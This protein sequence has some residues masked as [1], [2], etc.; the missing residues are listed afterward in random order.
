[1]DELLVFIIWTLDYFDSQEIYNIQ[2]ALSIPDDC[3]RQIRR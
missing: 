1:M 2:I 3:G